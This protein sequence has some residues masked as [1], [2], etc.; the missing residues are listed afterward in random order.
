MKFTTVLSSLLLSSGF[1]SA[2]LRLYELDLTVAETAPDGT[3]RKTYLVNGQTP[4]PDLIL[5]EGDDVSVTVKNNLDAGATVHFHGIDQLGSIWSDGVPGVTQAMIEPGDCFVANWT[6]KQHGAYWYVIGFA[7]LPPA[8]VA[9][10]RYHAHSRAIYGDGIRGG[11]FIRP[12]PE[13]LEES[14]FSQISSEPEDLEALKKAHNNPKLL[15][16]VDWTH[17][18]SET[19][20]NLWNASH[21]ELLCIDSVLVNGKGRVICP[22]PA[23]FVPYTTNNALVPNVTAKGC[24]LPTNPILQPFADKKPELI[25]SSIF[26]DCQ[27]STT[28]LEVFAVDAKDKWASFALINV[29]AIWDFK[30]S[31]DNHPIYIYAADGQYHDA[32]K[33]D[34]VNISPGERIQAMIKL[35]K[36][37]RDYAIRV[38]ANVV[39]QFISGYATLSYNPT[40]SSCTTIPDPVNQALG[41]GAD[42]LPGFVE[43]EPHSL[44]AF[45]QSLLPP[46]TASVTLLMEIF[47][48][49]AVT[50]SLDM[51]PFAP[52]LELEDPLLF[53]P[54]SQAAQDKNLVH[55]YPVGSIVDIVLISAPGN[56]AHPIHKHG[57]KAWIIG[58]GNGNWTWNTVEE[59]K[60]ANPDAFNLGRA[61]LRDGFSTLPAITSSSWTVIRYEAVED[62]VVFM[63][64]HIN[65]HSVTGMDVALIEGDPTRLQIPQYYVDFNNKA[66]NSK[67]QSKI[68]K[69]RELS[70]SGAIPGTLMPRILRLN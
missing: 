8:H 56:P 1:A 45:P 50:W 6:A 20:L 33:V 43:L 25:P 35:D 11:I 57:V 62:A 17:W 40:D 16:I 69:A 30:V 15:T 54:H 65:V 29:G 26:F 52:F 34:V 27:N 47:R 31:F 46:Q 38:A 22:D 64:C 36:D 12:S 32:Q 41:Y 66:F 39:P 23:T 10:D 42:T 21:I 4:G 49:S 60:Q 3:S 7:E 14:P 13:H 18:D 48:L 37:P 70:P 5:D 55:T 44:K 67:T 61:P 24:G 59:A 28:P 63:H 9:L 68:R 53:D 51:D 19:G 2:A 58:A